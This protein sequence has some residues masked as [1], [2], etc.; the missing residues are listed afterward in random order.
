MSPDLRQGEKHALTPRYTHDAIPTRYV[1]KL[2]LYPD[3]NHGAHYQFHEDFV[4]QAK[5][6]LDGPAGDSEQ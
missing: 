5:L 3:S 1:A 2:V 4:A 6:F